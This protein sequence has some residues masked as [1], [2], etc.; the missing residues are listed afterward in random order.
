MGGRKD[1]QYSSFLG[2]SVGVQEGIKTIQTTLD[3]GDFEKAS[4]TAIKVIAASDPGIRSVLFSIKLAKIGFEVYTIAE[5]EY[6]K[7]GNYEEAL[8]HAIVRIAER[9]LTNIGRSLV[10]EGMGVAWERIKSA[11]GITIAHTEIDDFVVDVSTNVLM[12]LASGQTIDQSYFL[13][14][15]YSTS[16]KMILNATID[17]KETKASKLNLPYEDQ[18]R[19]EMTLKNYSINVADRLF[20]TI[21][22]DKYDV[23][24]VSDEVIKSLIQQVLNEVIEDIESA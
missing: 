22:E 19:L 8:E 12:S 15:V 5:K 4:L 24:S 7:T 11:Q 2:S 10:E 9:E 6:S 14:E 3:A 23:N 1:Y 17:S 13:K 21:I 18:K 16:V 20:D